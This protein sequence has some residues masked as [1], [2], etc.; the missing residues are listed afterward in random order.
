MLRKEINKKTKMNP[1]LEFAQQSTSV[2]IIDTRFLLRIIDCIGILRSS[3]KWSEKDQAKMK[4]WCRQFADN[5]MERI[6]NFHK[7]RAHNISSFYHAQ[8]AALQLFT[9]DYKQAE[10]MIER[11]KA[12]LD[13]G[14]NSQ[15]GF[16]E[17][18][19]RTRSLSYSSFHCFALFN[20]ASMGKLVDIDLWN[21]TT[22]DGRG[23]FKA[24]DYITQNT[25]I[26][27]DKEWPHKEIEGAKGDW[28]K[29]FDDMMPVV[30][31]HAANKYH[32]KEFRVVAEQILGTEIE[33][34][35]IQ[36]LCGLPLRWME[37][38]S[39]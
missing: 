1:D 8:M 12:R 3:G 15:G 18:W 20:L 25:G 22:E 11:T 17:E 9:E 2:G 35:K 6:D 38:I 39:Y 10:I 34:Y 21:Y 37:T 14:L 30:L 5:V 33:E 29:P 19:R 16:K 24:L 13:S 32:N 7:S 28:W 31:Y 36:L 27:S 4:D 26:L 23:F